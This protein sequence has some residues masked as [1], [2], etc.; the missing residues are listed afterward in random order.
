MVTMSPE[1]PLMNYLVLH[2]SRS[3]KVMFELKPGSVRIQ[4]THKDSYMHKQWHLVFF[5]PQGLSCA[6]GVFQGRYPGGDL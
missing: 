6:G 4:S 2:S 5:K 1:H 3:P